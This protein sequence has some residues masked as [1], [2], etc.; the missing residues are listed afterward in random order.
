LNGIF[1][2]FGGD[3]E[4]MAKPKV[5]KVASVANDMPLKE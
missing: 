3:N 2:T 4:T 5:T 1:W